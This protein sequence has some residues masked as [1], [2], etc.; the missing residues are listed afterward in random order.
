MR[1]RF[2]AFLTVAGLLTV[3]SQGVA[4]TPTGT[5]SGHV[6]SP[7]GEALP[8][9]SVSVASPALQG[10]RTVVSSVN[11]DYIVPLLPPG[12]YSVTFEISGFETLK[13][14]RNVGGTQAVSLDVTM[15]LSAVTATVA[16]V[17]T[18]EPFVQTA[19]V[20][21]DFKQELMATLP[22]NRTVDATVLMAP[23]VHA[24]GPRGAF[25]LSGAQSYE[26]LFTVN[27]VVTTENLR[28][29]FFTLYIEDALQETT[30]AV[31]GVSAEYGR[32]G[33]G[34]VNAVTK[35]GGNR[36]SGSFR[37]S[38][39]N[40][41]WRSY[42][43]F[44]TTQRIANPT[45]ETK[46]DKTVPTYEATIGGPAIRDRL[47]F[48]GAARAQK[49][50]STRQT[51]GTLIPYVR[52]NDDKRYEAK[53][54]Y[55]P[56]PN[57]SAQA[58]YILVDNVL[59]NNTSFNVMDLAS[60][61][62]QG[63][64]MDLLAL[65]YS[66]I[67][68][69]NFFLE[70]QYSLR[71]L[72]FTDV[73][74]NTKDLIN[75]TGVTDQA[76]GGFRYWSP[77]F[78]AGSTCDGDEQRNNDD[79]ILK[80]SYFLSSKRSGSHHMVFGYDRYND[81]I[82]ANTHANGSDYRILGTTSII[83]GTKVYPQFLSNNTTTISW[84][85][86]TVLS[87]G[88]NLR[89]HSLFL[90][91]AW[92]VNGNLSLT[93]GLRWDKNQGED[94]GGQD[95]ADRGSL[96]PRLSAVWDPLADGRWAVS[97][98]YAR[99]VAAIA[100]NV[101]A[102]TTAAGNAATY[103]WFY[104]GP[105]INA[106]PN[107]P[108]VTTDVALRQLFD[109]FFA[110]GGTDRRPLTLANI[111]GTN[112]KILS[113]LKSPYA[114]EYAGGVS[115]QFGNRG[116]VRVD[117]MYRKYRDFY[118]QRIDGSTGQVS[119][120]LGNRYD[121]IVY[122]NTNDVTRKYAGLT[123]QAT[124]R[125]GERLDIGGNYTLSHAYGNLDGENANAGPTTAAVNAYPE[126]LSPSWNSP[127]GDLSIDQRHRVR[128]WG[129]YRAPISERAGTMIVGLVQ[130]MGSGVPYG[131]VGTVNSSPYVT[132]PGYVTPPT[133]VSYYFTSRDAFKTEATYRT[134]LSVNY[135]YRL[136]GGSATR[137]ELFFRGEL[138]NVFN[139]FQLCGCGAS[140]F[141]NGGLT[142]LTTIGQGLRTPT[143]NA[144]MRA[145][146]PFTTTPVQGVNWDY[147][148]T[149]TGFGKPLNAFAYTSPRIFRFSV[150]VRF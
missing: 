149:S 63:Q 72:K 36:F 106:D 101:A 132:N 134:D 20:A 47:W 21:T 120:P 146:N 81:R 114:N 150:G 39:A 145:F 100:S 130:Q 46:L 45:L 91:D 61:T 7:D 94:G 108:L 22:S 126:Y 10:V 67:L 68:R 24:T 128:F 102:S 13:E 52:T 123:T 60:L 44:E 79:F 135:S 136:P 5:I 112:V 34:M 37:T 33:G 138:L 140:V 116:T 28:G 25:S 117:A 54:T 32:F 12:E 107:G 64:P 93:L 8:G 17:G 85:P 88:S 1:F 127:E 121:L 124:Y 2:A 141:N 31:S 133:A 125:F 118:S 65:H 38:F 139:Q 42:T 105:A 87:T 53:V 23:S 137:A 131:A 40:D 48:F 55:T 99:Y 29:S 78:C 77:T 83:Q 15:P 35:S 122:E 76:R 9:V 62:D 95:V 6:V 142:D 58:S 19:Q 147:N 59:R 66:G 3:A 80:G 84:S 26:S 129:T 143:N 90:S 109:W 50:E 148:V 119:D 69:P 30:V 18:A 92:R 103:R 4:Q 75:G 86:L 74:A 113:P 27:G 104:Q 144:A 96:S 70:A 56:H 98:S 71:H 57:H 111:P 110:N 11:G 51:V 49:Q 16:V 43:P 41:S 115:R 73:G 82:K 14:V 97:G 89:M